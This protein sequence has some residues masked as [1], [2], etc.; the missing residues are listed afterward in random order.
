VAVAVTG[1]LTPAGSLEEI[2]QLRILV[3]DD[4]IDSAESLAVLLRLSGHEVATVAC[5]TDALTYSVDFQP[6]V[7]ILD[8]G[9]PD[10]DGYEVARRLR[11]MPEMRH[12]KLVAVTGYGQDEDRKH[13]RMAGFDYHFLKPVDFDAISEVLM[14]VSSSS[15]PELQP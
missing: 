6:R 13:S 4:N 8:I 12:A 7:V 11:E 10:I 5:G 1:E 2:P 9:L 14:T 3:V 15:V